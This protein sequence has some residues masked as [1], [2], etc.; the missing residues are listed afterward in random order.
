MSKDKTGSEWEPPADFLASIVPKT[1]AEREFQAH[2]PAPDWMPPT[3][4]P[5]APQDT[6]SAL[7]RELV[8]TIKELQSVLVPCFPTR[9]LEYL[10]PAAQKALKRSRLV[11]DYVRRRHAH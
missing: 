11:L 4:F 3:K 9:A 8:E 7:I 6:D 10:E 5:R 2:L 1:G